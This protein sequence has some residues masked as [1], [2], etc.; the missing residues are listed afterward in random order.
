MTILVIGG[1]GFI[2]QRVTRK[3]AERGQQVVCMDIN[4]GQA[5]FAGLESRV[6][7]IAGDVSQFADVTRAIVESKAERIVNLAYVLGS[8]SEKQP[9]LATRTNALG[10][11]NCFEAARLLGVRRVV[12]A[13]SLAWNGPQQFYGQRA[14]TEDDPPAAG[15]VYSTGKQFN[16]AMA[17]VYS[18]LYG[19][20]TVGIRPCLVFG[21][22]KARG[23]QSHNQLMV[24]PALGQ[25]HHSEMKSSARMLLVYVEDLAEIFVRLTL[26]ERP[27]FPVYH[28]GGHTTS[29]G[30]VAAIVRD[31]IPDAV[32]TF[33]DEHGREVGSMPYLVDD[34]RVREE[35]EFEHR[36]LRQA[37]QETITAT[38]RLAG[39]GERV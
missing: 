38:R 33:D 22:D 6:Q 2:G 11:D 14:V 29:F 9:Y 28:A 17:R 21:P 16:E 5:S 35:L 31:I 18:R 27:R 37:V 20:E 39:Q 10:M 3:L 24:Q 1:S 15:G 8:D 19:L 36:P 13:S 12:Y 25:P 23:T 32:I 26:A 34:R 7:V 30:E 4:P